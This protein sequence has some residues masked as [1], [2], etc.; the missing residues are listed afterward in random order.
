MNRKEGR[1][2]PVGSSHRSG[3]AKSVAKLYGILAN[4]GHYKGKQVLS[5]E[6]I[7]TLEEPVVTGVD[8]MLG[9]RKQNGMRTW[10]MPVIADNNF[11]KVGV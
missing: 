11:E 6:V 4:G 2:L 10:L 3:T 7:K 9:I 5:Q 8:Q 1:K